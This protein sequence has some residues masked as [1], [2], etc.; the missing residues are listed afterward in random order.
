MAT[1]ARAIAK[2]RKRVEENIDVSILAG[3]ETLVNLYPCI[4]PPDQ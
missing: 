2:V 1:I 4:A 3:A